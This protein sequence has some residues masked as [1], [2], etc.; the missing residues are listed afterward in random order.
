MFLTEDKTSEMTSLPSVLK[1]KI[2]VEFCEFI[3][4]FNFLPRLT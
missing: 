3:Y 4:L 2:Q 1:G